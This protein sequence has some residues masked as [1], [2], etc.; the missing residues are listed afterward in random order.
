MMYKA[1]VAVYS[2]IRKK[3]WTRTEYHLEFLMINLVVCKETARL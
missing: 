2:E 3:H 1:N